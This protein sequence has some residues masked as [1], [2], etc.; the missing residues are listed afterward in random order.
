MA[1]LLVTGASGLLG[2]TLVRRMR[3]RHKVLACVRRTLIRPE[4]FEVRSFD[5]GDADAVRDAVEAY[6]PDWICH[7][8]ALTN[9]DLCERDPLLAYHENVVVTENL[10]YAAAHCGAQLLHISTDSV[11]DGVRGSYSESDAPG[12]VNAYAMSKLTSEQR[13]LEIC[14][15]A[16]VV[17]TNFFGWN[18]QQKKSLAEWILSQLRSG[19]QI[20]AWT[21]V[22]FSPLFNGDLA[23]FL[24][25]LLILGAEGVFH[26]AGGERCSK[27]DFARA[28]AS[29]W[30]YDPDLVKSA[31]VTEAG[32]KAPRPSDTSLRS[33]R[34]RDL[35]GIADLPDL[36]SG[37]RAMRAFEGTEHASFYDIR[38]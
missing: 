6:H 27:F 26:V 1:R 8:A 2:A 21:D 3:D 25:K 37:L 5:L 35:L 22:C 4:G 9:V 34:L 14:P 15:H 16:L 19:T 36:R 29:V 11:F 28:I 30:E 24:E 18:L 31:T 12:P 13:A 17:R 23:D 20:R 7:A 10:A 32:L 33:L 38:Y